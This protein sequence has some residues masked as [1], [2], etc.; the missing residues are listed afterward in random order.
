MRFYE[1]ANCVHKVSFWVMKYDESRSIFDARK[2]ES[3]VLQ[4]M[5]SGEAA[6]T[7]VNYSVIIMYD[8]R[9]LT[10]AR[11]TRNAQK[12][13]QAWTGGSGGNSIEG[14]RGWLARVPVPVPLSK[15]WPDYDDRSM[16][17]EGPLLFRKSIRTAG[18]ARVRYRTGKKTTKWYPCLSSKFRDIRG[19]WA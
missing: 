18:H 3:P 16:I 4:I 19:I 11:A 17:Y 8:N 15:A 7:R 1:C 9:L 2:K 6:A 5:D 12:R 13:G 14:W 10:R